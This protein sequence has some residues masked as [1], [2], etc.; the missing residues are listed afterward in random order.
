ML[1]KLKSLFVIEDEDAQKSEAG[2][3]TNAN[4]SPKAEKV[5][6]TVKLDKSIPA[7]G[8]GKPDEKFVNRL[9]EAIEEHNQEGFDYLEY[10]QSI[11]SLNSMEMDEATKFKSSLAMASTMGAT[12]AKLV[13][14]AQHYLAVLKSEEEKFQNALSNQHDKIVSGTNSEIATMAKSIE[15]KEAQVKQLTQE[16]EE[17]KALLEKKKN[18]VDANLAKVNATKTG[19][20]AA[21]HIVVDQISSD[22][23]KMKT[24]LK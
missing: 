13:S 10:K 7:K 16:I 24:F 11:Q 5:E 18:G 8:E 23:E 12:P 14:S 17:T 9:L 21:Y 4:E 15:T 3:Q 19:F 1:K 20:Y 2:K 6:P 22:I